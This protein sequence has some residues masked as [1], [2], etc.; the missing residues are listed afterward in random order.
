[1]REVDWTFG[2]LWPYAP[3]WFDTPDGKVHYIDE[4]PRDGRPVVLVH[5][6]PTW[7]FL[8]RDFIRPL[9]GAGYRVIVPDFLG[10][11]RSDKPSDPA[12]Y[13]VDRH[14]RR[15]SDLLESLDLRG[16]VAVGQD[17]G[18]LVYDW[19]AEHPE[20]V[21]GLFILNTTVH[22]PET[23]FKVPFALHFFRAP[24]VGEI[25]VK[26]LMMFHKAFL[27]GVG[28]V[29][30][31]RLTEVVKQAYLAP[32]PTW[33]SRTGVLAFPRA[34]PVRPEGPWTRYFTEL[35]A[36]LS[37]AYRERPV[38]IVW[39]MKDPAFTSQILRGRWLRNLPQADVVELE[40]AG[41]Y[42]QEDAHEVI[43]PRLLEFLGVLGR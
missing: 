36:K 31:E 16:A 26:G 9:T 14:A 28:V 24:V 34:I 37:A 13:A 38:R 21:A 15:L 22:I 23:K 43:V 11:G 42:L 2:G 32:H 1:M 27:F 8:Y 18:G 39:A 20:R 33:S 12:V 4:G 41:H 10:F 25:M 35:E 3:R 19:A 7:G 5:G 6:N 17:W 30:R 29:H 40:D